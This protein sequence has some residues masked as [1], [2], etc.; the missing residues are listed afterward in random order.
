MTLRCDGTTSNKYEGLAPRKFHHISFLSSLI[1]TVAQS[2]LFA[3]EF[4]FLAIAT[5]VE[6][7]LSVTY[8][9]LI[10]RKMTLCFNRNIK[11]CVLYGYGQMFHSN[12]NGGGG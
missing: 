7:R 9:R 12:S 2:F 8:F 1:A 6:P 3:F 4:S 10:R 11:I 5:T